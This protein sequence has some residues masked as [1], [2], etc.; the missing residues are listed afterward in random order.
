MRNERGASCFSVLFSF[1]FS[2]NLSISFVSEAILSLSLVS[3]RNADDLFLRGS[4]VKRNGFYPARRLIVS[5]SLVSLR[6]LCL[7]GSTGIGRFDS[8]VRWLSS[9]AKD[10]SLSLWLSSTATK[11]LGD[12]STRFAQMK[13]KRYALSKERSGRFIQSTI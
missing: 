7:S 4:S 2:R 1:S 9:A 5:L 6:S 12:G 10:G 8:F 13:K 11:L 3:R